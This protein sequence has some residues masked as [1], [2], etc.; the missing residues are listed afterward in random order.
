MQSNA[1][2]TMKLP[3][4]LDQAAAGELL[5]Q[6]RRALDADQALRLDASEVEIMTLPAMQLILAALKT[7]DKFAIVNSSV[8][9]TAAF[10][11]AGFELKQ[12]QS[13]EVPASGVDQDHSPQSEAEPK[14]S[15]DQTSANGL[16]I[17]KRILT[18]D[19]SKTMRDML[20]LTLTDAGFKVLQAV[21]GQDGLDVL[22]REQVDVIITDINM[23]K[24]NGYEVIKHLRAN[25]DHQKT[26]ILVL[27]TESDQ[28]NKIRA[29]D[30]GANGW[31]VKPFDPERLADVINQVS[32]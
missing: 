19:D 3:A 22:K 12:E 20:L 23:P 14:Q 30:A 5:A 9:F 4:L 27:T 26:P 1:N 25:P 28:E 6:L 8:A 10:N 2:G 11:D 17:S 16:T 13:S 18:I 24:M 32:P 15:L 29:R 31:I 7:S 21:D